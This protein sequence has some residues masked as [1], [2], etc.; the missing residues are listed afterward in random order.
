MQSLTV[1]ERIHTEFPFADLAMQMDQIN[2]S[3]DT[4][5]LH[6][7]LACDVYARL[8]KSSKRVGLAVV[9]DEETADNWVTDLQFF[10]GESVR[11]L[12]LPKLEQ[13]SLAHLGSERRAVIALH[14]VLSDVIWS[15]MP[16]LIVATAVAIQ[17]K[18]IPRSNF[19][20]RT[21][22]LNVAMEVDR[23]GLASALN[24]AGY[25][26]V[27]AVEDVGT[28]ALRGA[29]FDVFPAGASQPY[30]L[31]LWGDEIESIRPFS[32]STQRCT[33]TSID[34][35]VVP[36]A[37]EAAFDNESRAR[38]K[39]GMLDAAGKAGIPTRQLQ[40]LIEDLNHGI[41][42]VGIEAVRSF[43]YGELESIFDYL[44][45]HLMVAWVDPLGCKDVWQ[46][47]YTNATLN[48]ERALENQELTAPPKRDLIAEADLV[49]LITSKM[50]LKCHAL[51][52]NSAETAQAIKFNT[53]EL[54]LLMTTF[55]QSRNQREPLRPLVDYLR[56]CQESGQAVSIVCRQRLQRE[57]LERVVRSFGLPYELQ[58]GFVYDR[59]DEKWAVKLIEGE[60][61]SSV[62][63]LEP[64]HVLLSEFDVFGAKVKRRA[65]KSADDES[66]FIQDFRELKPSDYVVHADHGIGQYQG[67][68]KLTLG[69]QESDF[70]VVA[71][72]GQDKLYLPIYKLGR[73]QKYSGSGQSPRVTKLGGTS[74]EKV[75]QRAKAAAEEDALALLDLYARREM[76]SGYAFSPPDDYFQSFESSFPFEETQDQARSISEVLADMGR[77][78][79]MDRLLCGDVGFGKTEVALRAAFRAVSDGKQVCLL[80]PT[81]VLSLQHFK[82]FRARFADYPIEVALFSRLVRS[83]ELKSQ[84]N[85]LR[86]GRIDIAIGTHRL[87]GKD[88]KFHD[89]GLLVLDEEHRFGV[90]HKDRIKEFRANVDVLAMTAT[91]IPR[92]LQMSL[93]GIRDLSVI[94]TPPLDRL[95]IRTFVCRTTEDVVK[96][97]IS[98]ELAR[99]GQVFF[100][101][102]RVQSIDARAAWLQSL[103][104]EARIAVGHGQMTPEALEKVMLDFTNGLHNVLMA[105]TII[106]SGIDIPSANTML[107][108]KADQ[109]GLAQLYQLRGRVGRGKDR[110]YCYLMVPSE[111]ALH[112]DAKARLS[113][114]QQFTELGSGFH[115]ASHDLEQR[116]AGELLGTRQKGHVQSVGIDLYAELLDDAVRALRGESA[117]PVF[118]PELQFQVQARIPET[119]IEADSLRLRFYKRFSN[120]ER[121]ET[122]L[123]LLEELSER[124]GEAPSS[125]LNLVEL[126]RIRCLSKRLGLSH[127]EQTQGSLHLTFDPQ[128]PIEAPKIF[129]LIQNGGGR[130]TVPANYKLRYQFSAEEQRNTL[131]SSRVCLQEIVDLTMERDAERTN[132]EV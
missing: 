57:R 46:Q 101:H 28:F 9:P 36:P 60:V 22:L 70:L 81:T 80:V 118:D 40:P 90:K 76:T 92:T 15:D 79:P 45:D 32:A 61:S 68:K 39:R 48:H 98:R 65:R 51:S 43:F 5:G 94:R 124:F 53:P 125:V 52:V 132:V 126:M 33:E 17:R 29:V 38:A 97:A 88:V 84:L 56:R 59:R 66:P 116:G 8:L 74:W 107:I 105:T 42:F 21:Q 41:P 89:L 12:K 55:Q 82:T 14:G 37:R 122:I 110:G 2:G 109:F 111:L 54:S 34:V 31:E 23:D 73:L 87:L 83:G 129:E 24:D 10:H 85:D 20:A 75:K 72:A 108:D 44:P 102:N 86:A 106:E 58:Q 27:P 100:V 35:L 30:R 26:S 64:R 104:P 67:L 19:D 123:A 50:H 7:P 49:K 13:V 121:E 114:I 112:K 115:V 91:P 77:E 6:G 47:T 18:L 78:R 119:Y 93:S 71:F 130:F 96:E 69:G 95:S 62:T 131:I 120:A 103:V 127:V 1:D 3:A 113:V 4:L 128:T 16:I 11:V 117:K 99:G 25:L 63:L